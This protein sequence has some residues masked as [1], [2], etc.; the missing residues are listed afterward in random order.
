M[1]PVVRGFDSAKLFREGCLIRL[2]EIEKDLARLE[3]SVRRLKASVE[4]SANK[5]KRHDE[6]LSRRTGL[7]R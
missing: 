2:R 5:M 6:L 1:R 4:E 7:K 3:E